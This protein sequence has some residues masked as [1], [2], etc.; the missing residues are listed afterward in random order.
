MGEGGEGRVGART[1]EG[2]L[3]YR[4]MVGDLVTEE[5]ADMVDQQLAMAWTPRESYG[6]SNGWRNEHGAGPQP[7]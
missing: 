2:A 7:S 4:L 6:D 5:T 1:D 3:G